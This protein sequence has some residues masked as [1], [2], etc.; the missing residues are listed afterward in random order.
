MSFSARK[1]D[2]LKP[3]KEMYLSTFL[4][5]LFAAAVLFVP[6]MIKD[7]GYFLFYGDFNVQQ[8]PF[9]KLCHE[10]ILSGQTAWN[11]KTDLGVNFI[12][13]YSFYTLG[14][15]FFLLTLLFPES[16]VPY[17]MGPLL[18]LKFACAALTSYCFI[19]RFTRLPDTARIGALLYAFS[20]FSVY[21]IF[22][23][24]FHEAIII[25]PLL[26]L[27]IE[28]FITENKRGFFGIMVAVCAIVNYFFFF[29]MVVFAVLY[30]IVRTVSGC[31]KISFGRFAALA[32]EAILGLGMSMII[33][34]PTIICVFQN[35]RLSEIQLGWNAILYGKE[36]IYPNIIQCFFFPP[37]LPAR[38]VFFP[39][40]DVKWSSLG[41][42]LPLFSMVGI[43]AVMQQ[44]KRSW[45]RRLLGIC[46]F[47]ALVPIL[48]SL[49]YMLNAAYYARWFYMPILIMCL[50]TA[51]CLE[52]SSVDFKSP[53]RW[54]LGITL[55]IVAVI[56][57]FPQQGEDGKITFGLY[58]YDANNTYFYRFIVTSAIAIAAL[59]ALKLILPLIKTNK[60]TFLNLSTALV[61]VFSM[62]Y[63]LVFIATGKSH[64][65]DEKSVM[66]DQLLE[67]DF[68]LPNSDTYRVD[69]YDGVDNT[70]M[71]LNLSSINAFHSIV[72]ASVTDFWEYLGEER[73]VG[74][75]PETDTYAARALLSCKYLLDREGRDSNDTGFL[76]EDGTT[77][78]PGFTYE[79]TMSGYKI[80]K[81]ENYIPYGFTYDY[82]VTLKQAEEVTKSKRA[83]L[84]VKA[85]LLSDKQISKYGTI[86]K[87]VNEEQ[88]DKLSAG[89]NSDINSTQNN[90]ANGNNAPLNSGIS[91]NSQNS[92]NAQA[93]QNF[94]N[95]QNPQSS[96]NSQSSPDSQNSENSQNSL[97]SQNI[98]NNRDS[99]NSLGNDVLQQDKED[100]ENDYLD[101]DFNE[102]TLKEDAAARAASSGT[103]ATTKNGFTEKITLT[104]QNLV[105]FSI[106]YDSGWSATVNGKPAEIEKVNVGF[107][108]VL[109]DEG[110]NEIVFTYKTPGL[111]NGIL[112]TLVSGGIFVA[113]LIICAIVL[114][115]NRKETVY[116]E[117]E[118][119]LAFFKE[120]EENE[121][122]TEG[123]IL[124]N[125][126][127]WDNIKGLNDEDDEPDD[128]YNFNADLN[129]NI[130]ENSNENSD[131]YK[132]DE[133]ADKH[134]VD[135][136]N[137][138]TQNGFSGGFNVNIN[139]D[140]EDENE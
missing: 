21:N 105:F 76:N 112:I 140:D 114:K 128:F 113:Y 97:N 136:F 85:L 86:L 17:L 99:Q 45:Q 79:S 7:S 32:F 102:Q 133:D 54:V 91:Q 26:L 123:E 75:R 42:W 51:Q 53:Y 129:E 13:S 18:I 120:E 67:N 103:F 132:N 83:N 19:R 29:G 23:N 96:E 15:P 41:G 14:S 25:F 40:A 70:A 108:A 44:K 115:T 36:Q 48:N 88:K 124:Y 64:S 138:D 6:F 139:I 55:A 8:I 59:L 121:P 60:K 58:T 68:D 84:M 81:N 74:S 69:V 34:L 119:L 3:K 22:F 134:E 24:H 92:Q 137:K 100:F 49:F 30:F 47:M 89:N 16:F 125:D 109:A 66:I 130:K 9:Y 50:C 77:K 65:Y 39:D 107:M 61:L 63:G 37:D 10:A 118:K 71:Y 110:E 62:V 72:P 57:F 5:A 116:P 127:I 27:S 126:P 93:L 46:I 28:L 98:Q 101:I 43:F 20:G 11:F 35:S 135:T 31:Y 38:P 95:S 122:L 2:L 106:P 104:K 33:L 56:G 117:G 78:M 4:L 52:D 90:S 82:Y 1:R 12:G 80:Y 131:N 87:N 111:S 94:Q 73:G